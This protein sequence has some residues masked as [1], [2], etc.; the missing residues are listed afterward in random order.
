MSEDSLP[1]GKIVQL[2]S[3]TEITVFGRNAGRTAILIEE[4]VKLERQAIG[5][6]LCTRQLYYKDKPQDVCLVLNEELGK[7]LH[8]E[9]PEQE[10]P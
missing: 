10:V 5:E 8:G 2:S 6:W 4:A 3:G 1:I 9:R 7:L